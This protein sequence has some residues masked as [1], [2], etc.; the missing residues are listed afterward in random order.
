MRKRT[1]DTAKR[2]WKDTLAK[3]V[4]RKGDIRRGEKKEN[5]S[6][7][8]GS[9]LEDAKRKRGKKLL[10]RWEDR[11]LFAIT[12]PHNMRKKS[13]RGG[14]WEGGKDRRKNKNKGGRWGGVG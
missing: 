10:K 1:G 9:I 2:S 4:L 6:K 3:N 8:K 7:R 12:P 13:V 14:R 11:D 5:R